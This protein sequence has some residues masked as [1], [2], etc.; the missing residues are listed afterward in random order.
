YLLRHEIIA[1]HT[2]QSQGGAEFYPSCSQLIVTGSS[3]GA[4]KDSELG[5]LPGAYKATGPEI[6]ID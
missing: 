3:T 1:L 4:P 2:A 6:L 5:S